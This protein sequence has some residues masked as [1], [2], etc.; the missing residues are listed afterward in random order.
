MVCVH[1]SHLRC[2]ICTSPGNARRVSDRERGVILFHCAAGARWV[3]CVV[4]RCGCGFVIARREIAT[5]FAGS[6]EIRGISIKRLRPP[7]RLFRE[8]IATLPNE[9]L[10]LSPGDFRAFKDDSGAAAPKTLVDQSP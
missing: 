2:C 8:R 7:E 10:P 9:G 6:C 5:P 3:G 1:H 4:W